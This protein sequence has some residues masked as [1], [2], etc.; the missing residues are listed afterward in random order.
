MTVSAGRS[1]HIKFLLT[2]ISSTEISE[3]DS[4]M[5]LRIVSIPRMI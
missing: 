2:G 3:S 4:F 1:Y 5:E